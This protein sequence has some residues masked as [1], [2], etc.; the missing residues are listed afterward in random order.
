MIYLL[1]LISSCFG[2]TEFFLPETDDVKKWQYATTD[3]VYNGVNDKAGRIELLF[4]PNAFKSTLYRI[5]IDG[6]MW[7][8]KFKKIYYNGIKC[9]EK[10]PFGFKNY[11]SLKSEKT[12]D[13]TV[14]TYD[15]R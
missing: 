15:S 7:D 1:M 8:S 2:S 3:D 12:T 4:Q 14:F 10:K 6:L 5:K 11:C 13:G 9:G